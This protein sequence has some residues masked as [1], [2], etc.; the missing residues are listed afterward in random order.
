M[1]F[2]KF[3]DCIYYI[4]PKIVCCFCD[5]KIMWYDSGVAISDQYYRLVFYLPIYLILFQNVCLRFSQ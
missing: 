5:V 3:C 4:S 1:L 2:L